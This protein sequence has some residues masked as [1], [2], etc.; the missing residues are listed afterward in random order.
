MHRLS[1]KNQIQRYYKGFDSQGKNFGSGFVVIIY[2]SEA[3]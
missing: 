3:C 2:L 1:H